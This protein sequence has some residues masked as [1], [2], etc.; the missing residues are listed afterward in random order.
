MRARL[1]NPSHVARVTLQTITG[2]LVNLGNE[3]ARA[4]FP[5]KCLNLQLGNGPDS[6]HVHWQLNCIW[7][8]GL[9]QAPTLE[10]AL[11]AAG[12]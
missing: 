7:T 3:Q 10:K 5:G 9:D 6:G 8:V 4:K 2:K 12:V 1:F 11:V